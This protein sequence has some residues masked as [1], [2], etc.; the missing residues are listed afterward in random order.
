MKQYASRAPRLGQVSDT[1]IRL[2]RV[3]RAVVECGGMSAAELELNI[4][5]S[6]ISRHVK[7]LE[8]RLGG[9]TLCHR[10]RGGFSLTDEGREV[11]DE[12]LK[13]LASMD[14]FRTRIDELHQRL[15][16]TLSVAFLDKIVTNPACALNEALARFTELAPNVELVLHVEEINAIERALLDGRYH[17]GLVPEHRVSTALDYHPLFVEHVFLYCGRTHPLFDHPELDRHDTEILQH[18]YA[19]LGYHSHNM[20]ITHSLGLKRGAT[21]YDQ[22]GSLALLLSGRYLAFLPDSYARDLVERGEMRLIDNSRFRYQCPYSA[23]V[24]HAPKPSRVVQTFLD[25][26]LEA[27]GSR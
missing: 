17:V 23:I 8:V 7:D 19:G 4:G 21:S 5:R 15:T 16:G 1:D 18:R 22:E 2:L 20:D 26:L 14:S 12:T 25:C 10:G 9:L 24:R 11:Y 3:F 27:H 13:L 6:T